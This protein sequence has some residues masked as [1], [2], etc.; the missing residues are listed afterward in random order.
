MKTTKL[1]KKRP[2]SGSPVRGRTA[3]ALSGPGAQQLT[4][5]RGQTDAYNQRNLNIQPLQVLQNYQ[6]HNV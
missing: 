5:S 3:A 4:G 1:P 6:T 2:F